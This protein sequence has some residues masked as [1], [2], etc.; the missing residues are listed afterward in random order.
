MQILDLIPQLV[1]AS[2]EGDKKMIEATA[3]MIIKK[4]KKEY[5]VIAEDI[6]KVLSYADVGAS[7]TR[8]L[9]LPPPTSA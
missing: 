8:A 2:F 4:I 1:R 7:P 9:D 6:A 3:L 5:P